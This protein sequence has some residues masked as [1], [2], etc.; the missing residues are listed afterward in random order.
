MAGPLR[1]KIILPFVFLLA[2]V[3]IAGTAASTLKLAN[4][5]TSEFDDALFRSGVLAND[6]LARIE[7]D[8]LAE[9]RELTDT[10][11]VPEALASHET[12]ALTRL[13]APIALNEQPAEV[14]LH[15]LDRLGTEVLRITGPTVT[16]PQTTEA[17]GYQG[18]K[19]VQQV[20]AGREDDMGERTLFLAGGADASVNWIGPIKDD[21][22]RIQGAVIEQQP[23][24][25]LAAN[26]PDAVFYDLDGHL[27]ASSAQASPALPSGARKTVSHDHPMRLIGAIASHQYGQLFSD[28]TMRSRQLG[29][30]AVV[31]KADH[32]LD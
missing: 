8:R 30:L 25:S 27:L 12:L 1:Y 17:T 24:K 26:I 20:L 4:A 22:D 7:S 14:T 16:S 23:L 9:L 31:Y 29:Y 32:L 21:L 11:G 13:L 5:A 15:V 2:F 18:L 6:Q 19:S 10:V 3:G 28:W